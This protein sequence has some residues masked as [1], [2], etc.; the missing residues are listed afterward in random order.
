MDPAVSYARWAA[1]LKFYGT[2]PY[3][4]KKSTQNA[5]TVNAVPYKQMLKT[6]RSILYFILDVSFVR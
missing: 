1:G 6:F 3:C 2:V 4:T 5:F